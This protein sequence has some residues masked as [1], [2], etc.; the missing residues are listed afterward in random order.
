MSDLT[1]PEKRKFERL[2]D[3]DSGYVLNFSNRTFADFVMDSTG[4]DINDAEYNYGSGSKA[5]C[6]RGFWK[7]E[8]NFV[9]GKLM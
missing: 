8:P 5:N 4:K 9:V 6:L 2:L 7:E 3:M 1:G